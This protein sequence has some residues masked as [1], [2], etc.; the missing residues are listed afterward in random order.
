[1][2]AK[3]SGTQVKKRQNN[4]YP[5]GLRPGYLK[6]FKRKIHSNR[7]ARRKWQVPAAAVLLILVSF[8]VYFFYATKLAGV[9]K[10]KHL[11]GIKLKTDLAP[12]GN[13]AVLTLADG[14]NILL[15]SASN[16]T[17]SQ[18]GNIKIRKLNSGLMEYI[19]KW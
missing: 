3:L 12:G 17:L 18:Q 16:G 11:P 8:G 14:S 9:K 4:N 5:I 1:M 7:Q 10:F 15:D 13:K 2:I 19:Y 6:Q